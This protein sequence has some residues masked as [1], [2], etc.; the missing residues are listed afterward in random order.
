MIESKI[1]AQISN[2]IKTNHKIKVH[3]YA[4]PYYL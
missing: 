2:F 3:V 1:Y 4:L